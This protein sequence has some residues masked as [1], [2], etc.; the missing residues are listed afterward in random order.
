MAPGSDT[1][2]SPPL[3]YLNS[4][5]WRATPYLLLRTLGLGVSTSNFPFD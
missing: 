1:Q 5:L 2:F 4:A 3:Q